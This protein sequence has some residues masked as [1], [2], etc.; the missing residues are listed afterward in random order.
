MHEVMGWRKD[1]EMLSG[2][3]ID[4][5]E[6]DR[7]KK[8]VDKFGNSF[9]EKVFTPVEIEY[10]R[11]KHNKYQHLAARFAAKEAVYKALKG[12][13][14]KNVWFN[15]IEIE[16]DDDGKPQVKLINIDN[17]LFPNPESIHLSI[18]HSQQYAA[19]VAIIEE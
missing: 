4:I 15:N 16:N 6:I 17:D 12:S 14:K 9:L 18:T 19:A 11:T 3:G 13:G 8:S 10:A 2:I 5:I 7:I 1:F